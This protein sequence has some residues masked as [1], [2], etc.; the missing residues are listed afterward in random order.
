[1]LVTATMPVIWDYLRKTNMAMALDRHLRVAYCHR[2]GSTREEQC[3]T[4]WVCQANAPYFNSGVCLW[5]RSGEVQRL[6]TVWNKEWYRFRQ[7][8]QK[9]LARALEIT[10]L[11][12]TVLDQAYNTLRKPGEWPDLKGERARGV[13]ILH[14][15]MLSGDRRFLGLKP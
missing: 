2:Q 8:D 6:F 13:K 12:V 11:K 1:M 15:I 7:I 10:K 5:R 3:Y 9:A 14:Y 4:Q